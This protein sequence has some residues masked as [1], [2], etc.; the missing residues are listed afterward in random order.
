V[1]QVRRVRR[2]EYDCQGFETGLAGLR[3]ER[4]GWLMRTDEVEELL[5]AVVNGEMSAADALLAV[6][7]TRRAVR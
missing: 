7:D 6:R 3:E 5:L 4:H 1:S 2:Y